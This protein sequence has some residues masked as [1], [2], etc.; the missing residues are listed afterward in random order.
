MTRCSRPTL[1]TVMKIHMKINNDNGSSCTVSLCCANSSTTD[2]LHIRTRRDDGGSSGR[3]GR[4]IHLLA[5]DHSGAATAL[6]SY[7]IQRINITRIEIFGL[8]PE[9]FSLTYKPLIVILLFS[10]PS[11]SFRCFVS[12]AVFLLSERK[13]TSPLV[14]WPES[15]K[16]HITL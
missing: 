10:S 6:A 2:A 12:S 15:Y 14:D 1:S 16:A 7:K 3:L 9:L 8:D 4:R 11:S 5:L 13:F